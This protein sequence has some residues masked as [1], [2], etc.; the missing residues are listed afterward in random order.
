MFQNPKTQVNYGEC[1]TEQLIDGTLKVEE[2]NM[3]LQPKSSQSET[4][5]KLFLLALQ[6][7]VIYLT[8]RTEA[9]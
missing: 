2:R 3:S 5:A 7:V 8:G 9:S 1:P 6:S 4:K